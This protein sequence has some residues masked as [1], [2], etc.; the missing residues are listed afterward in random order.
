[1]DE[2]KMNEMA[3][4]E[5]RS[6]VNEL[7][8]ASGSMFST[9]KADTAEEKA[10]LFN[11]MNN[12]DKRVSDMIGKVIRVKDVFAE[13][14]ELVNKETGEVNRAPRIVLVDVDGVAYQ[15][16]SIGVMSALKK[17]FQIYGLPT[18][19]TGIP[20]EVKQIKNGI[21]NILTF[22]VVK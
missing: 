8:E 11:V 16:V 13:E 12:P 10:Q 18:W 15:A 21:N 5:T 9:L 6:Y 19:E 7:Q 3:V 22:S 1:M 14:V 17:L 4:F 20:L 2:L